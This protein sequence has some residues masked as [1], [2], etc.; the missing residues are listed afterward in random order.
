MIVCLQARG[1][2]RFRGAT[3][4][5]SSSCY[6]TGGV[7]CLDQ[8]ELNPHWAVRKALL[9]LIDKLNVKLTGLVE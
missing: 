4:W 7:D 5:Y 8:S 2:L 3:V 1:L 6:S 9:A